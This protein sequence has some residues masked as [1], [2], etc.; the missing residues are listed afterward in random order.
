MLLCHSSAIAQ[1]VLAHSLP[2]PAAP[3]YRSNTGLTHQAIVR[4][5]KAMKLLQ[6]TMFAIAALTSSYSVAA[7]PPCETEPDR[8]AESITGSIAAGEKFE[9]TIP[10]NWIFKLTPL[11]HGWF[12]GVTQPGREEEDL[13][14]LTPPLHG[15]NAIYIEGWHFRN[16]T[17][18][19]PNTGSLNVPQHQRDFIF[20]PEVGRT[21]NFNGADVT[22]DDIDAIRAYGRGWLYLDAFTLTPVKEGAQAAFES[23]SFT[24]CLTWPAAQ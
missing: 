10:G 12:I 19:G 7:A 16:E 9:A 24:A 17:N 20:S 13:S 2:I 5:Y 15:P 14:R 6:T 22:I 3:D 8:R 1:R 21:I 23:I 18:T 4:G 11:R